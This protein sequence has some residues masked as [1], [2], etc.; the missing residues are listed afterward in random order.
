MGLQIAE[1]RLQIARPNQSAFCSQSAFCNL[2]SAIT[3]ATLFVLVVAADSVAQTPTFN[4]DVARILYARCVTCHRPGE[5][6]PMSLV[7]YDDARPW[8]RA[9]RARVSAREMPPWFADPRFGR[10]FV[11]DP[12]LTDPEIQTIVEWVDAGAPRG[13]GE[14]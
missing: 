6:A 14:A 11:N 4:Q 3:A 2:Q 5:A 13:S 7:T 10:P 1:C 8:V 9:I 12:R